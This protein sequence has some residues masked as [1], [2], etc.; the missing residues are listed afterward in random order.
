MKRKRMKGK[1]EGNQTSN[2]QKVIE[3]GREGG[4]GRKSQQIREREQI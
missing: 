3:S 2:E 1:T 4:R